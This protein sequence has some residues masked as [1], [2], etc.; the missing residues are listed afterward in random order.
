MSGTLVVQTLRGPASGANANK[1]IVPSG[2]TFVPSAGQVVNTQH[3]ETSTQVDNSSAAWATV[4]QIT[5]TPTLTQSTV[6]FSHNLVLRT[7]RN[8]GADGRG[9]YRVLINGTQVHEDS[10]MGVYD[11]GGSGAYL[12]GSYGNTQVW[13]N[14]TGATITVQY[15]TVQGNG[16]GMNFNEG[17]GTAKSSVVATEIA[18]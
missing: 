10:A 18:Q 12:S 9:K 2:Q 17:A 3:Y 1:I 5:Y 8:N 11:Y 6:L 15:Q 16:L 4:W 7:Y 14:T 13:N